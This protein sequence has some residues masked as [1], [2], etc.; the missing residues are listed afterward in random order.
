MRKFEIEMDLVFTGVIEIE[1]ASKDDAIHKLMQRQF[2]IESIK[3]FS[4]TNTVVVGMDEIK[5]SKE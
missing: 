3:K 5:R 2:D 4:H 1:A